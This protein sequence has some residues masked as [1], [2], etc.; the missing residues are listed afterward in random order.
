VIE[1]LKIKTLSNNEL[2]EHL[3]KGKKLKKKVLTYTVSLIPCK[4]LKPKMQDWG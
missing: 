1:D 3:K 2:K 4:K